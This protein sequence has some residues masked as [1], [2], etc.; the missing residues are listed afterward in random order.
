MQ[1]S[2]QKFMYA[3]STSSR[4][5]NQKAK[6]FPSL[7]K[8]NNLVSEYQPKVNTK[9]NVA[10][11]ATDMK[12]QYLISKPQQKSKPVASSKVSIVVK[13]NKQTAL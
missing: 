1:K 8:P 9:A 4:I 2:N 6:V 10:P 11:K 7:K 12:S 13:S 3:G 5:E